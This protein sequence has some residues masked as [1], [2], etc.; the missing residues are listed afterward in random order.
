MKAVR[1]SHSIKVSS[2]RNNNKEKSHPE[3][4]E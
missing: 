4:E 3:A 1:K 2:K